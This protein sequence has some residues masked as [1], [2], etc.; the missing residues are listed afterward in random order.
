MKKSFRPAPRFLK[1]V[2][3]MTPSERLVGALFLSLSA[4]TDALAAEISEIAEELARNLPGF[5]VESCKEI[6]LAKRR[7]LAT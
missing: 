5:V 3:E 7:S 4:P 6:A 2:S 1:T